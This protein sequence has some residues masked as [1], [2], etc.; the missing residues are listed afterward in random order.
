[1]WQVGPYITESMQSQLVSCKSSIQFSS[2]SHAYL[3]PQIV[4][5]CNFLYFWLVTNGSKYT[6]GH[7]Y[8]C[9]YKLKS[10][11]HD[12]LCMPFLSVSLVPAAY[13]CT[14]ILPHYL[15]HC[16]LKNRYIDQCPHL[17]C[18][19]AHLQLLISDNGASNRELCVYRLC[20]GW[21]TCDVEYVDW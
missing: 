6:V 18:L 16:T 1:M 14:Y 11:H 20:T 21:Q 8:V 9:L 19:S 2:V 10:R 5:L 7:I 15:N 3:T 12:D 13:V 17:H 4:V